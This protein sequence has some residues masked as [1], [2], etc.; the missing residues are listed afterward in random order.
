MYLN[1]GEVCMWGWQWQLLDCTFHVGRKNCLQYWR[2]RVQQVTEK[3][4]EY[5]NETL[6]ALIDQY[7]LQH[8]FYIKSHLSFPHCQQLLLHNLQQERWKDRRSKCCKDTIFNTLKPLFREERLP[9][10]VKKTEWDRTIIQI[11]TFACQWIQ[12][13]R[14]LSQ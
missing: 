4:L 14:K 2:E 12:S 13:I 8:S 6:F 11:K 10:T 1:K 3:T 5:G 7:F 9:C